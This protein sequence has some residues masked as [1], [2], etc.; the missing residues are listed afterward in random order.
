MAEINGCALPEDLYYYID[1]HVWIRPMGEGVVRLG[2]TPVAYKLLRNTLVA[3]SLQ[4]SRIGQEV[5]QGRSIA[6]VESLKYIG[7]L[8]AP[9]DGVLVRGNDALIDNPDIASDDPYGAG[10]IAE[11]RPTDWSAAAQELL[12]GEAAMTAFRALLE[13]QGIRCDTDE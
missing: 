13:A 2:M 5:L 3:V 4:T 11:M 12:T 8:P 1:K 6:M 10:W 9:F 7:G